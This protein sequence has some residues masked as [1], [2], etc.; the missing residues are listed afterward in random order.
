MNPADTSTSPKSRVSVTVQT[1]CCSLH[2]ARPTGRL[3]TEHVTAQEPSGLRRSSASLPPTPGSHWLWYRSHSFAGVAFRSLDE[4]TV[5]TTVPGHD[6]PDSAAMTHHGLGGWTSARLFSHQ[7][8]VRNP[9][10]ASPGQSPGVGRA[11]LPPEALGPSVSLPFPAPGGCPHRELPALPPTAPRPCRTSS[12][13]RPSPALPLFPLR[14]HWSRMVSEFQVHQLGHL[15]EVS[16][17][18]KITHT[19]PRT[20]AWMSWG[21]H[22]DPPH[23][24]RYKS[25]SVVQKVVL[26]LPG[27]TLTPQA[28][29]GFCQHGLSILTLS[30][31]GGKTAHTL[32][33]CPSAPWCSRTLP[34]RAA[35]HRQAFFYRWVGAAVRLRRVFKH[36]YRRVFGSL[37]P[38]G[39]ERSYRTHPWEALMDRPFPYVVGRHQSGTPKSYGRC[40]VS[41][42]EPAQVSK[43]AKPLLTPVATW[44]FRSLP[45]RT[46]T[47]GVLRS[48]ILA[49]CNV[50]FW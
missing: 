37:Q 1:G 46:S 5:Q 17:P 40:I 32:G 23:Q 4:P 13:A 39:C 44:R 15:C 9:K 34:G 18:Y 25:M 20:G 12:A 11:F 50:T 41:L 49:A 29:T 31:E 45:N 43:A 30:W 48:L 2:G 24:S 35:N 26:F 10:R 14:T 6:F 36:L 3:P 27:W 7:L 42:R 28:T 16:L 21:H 38:W 33:M 47:F 8:A 19:G 22:F